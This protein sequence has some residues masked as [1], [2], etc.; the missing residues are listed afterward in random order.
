V[1]KTVAQHRGCLKEHAVAKPEPE[2]ATSPDLPGLAAAAAAERVKQQALATRTRERHAAVQQLLAQGQ[3]IKPIMREL[4]LAKETVRRFARA[5]SVDELLAKAR[6]GKPSVLDEH[7]PYLHQRWNEGCTTV[8]TL[9]NEIKS[10]G[11]PGSYGTVRE[12]LRPFRALGAAPAPAPAPPKVRDVTKWLLSRTET[13]DTDEQAKLTAVLARCTHLEAA[14]GH[15]A[16]FAD[17]LTGLH[18]E[19]L[20]DWIA[21]VE[22]DDLPELRSFTNGLKRDRAAVV[23]GLTLPHSSG[24]VEGAVNRIILWNLAPAESW[25]PCCLLALGAPLHRG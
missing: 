24:P 6:D 20:D 17:L 1:E 8:Q 10:R 2:T 18:G 23:N 5:G 9:F 19:R 15:V 4:G 11:Y 3:G 21:A 13:L 22:A 12:Y 14:A 16:T 25:R 7:K